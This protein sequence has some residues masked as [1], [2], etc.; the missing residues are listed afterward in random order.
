MKTAEFLAWAESVWSA[1]AA[2]QWDNPG[3][4]SGALDAEHSKALLTVD[5]TAEVLEE[6]IESGCSLIIAHHPLL[7]G[8]ID[9]LRQDQYKGFILAKAIANDIT[10]FAAHTNADVV[11]GGVS[12]LL[13]KS[14][15]LEKT[16]ALDGSPEGHGRVGQISPQSLGSFLQ[17]IREAIP[18][19]AKG[20]SY[21]GNLQMTVQTVA[22]VAGSGMSFAEET[23][24]DVFITS[25][26]KHHPALDFKQQA[27]LN[28]QQALVEVSHYAAES[29]WLDGV[30]Q[31][32][33]AFGLEAQVSQI[34]TD[35]W[36]GVIR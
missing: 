20:I 4:I 5:I 36:D 33:L 10:L 18:S 32:L 15:G 3:L 6:A 2:E 35:P 26:I 25:D 11:T 23:D 28:K 24:A 19:S 27:Q 34:N 31:Q 7:L 9:S 29:I 12:D 21:I 16:I 8:G 30:R 14:L 1:S 17:Q 22:L 13:A